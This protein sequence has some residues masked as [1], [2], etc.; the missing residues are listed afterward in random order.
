MKGYQFTK[1]E[2]QSMDTIEQ[3]WS[4]D[5]L[6]IQNE[7]VRI[8]LTHRENRAYDSDYQVEINVDGRWICESFSFGY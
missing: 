4:G 5:E 8:W 2:L 6:K 1:H 7:N 3:S